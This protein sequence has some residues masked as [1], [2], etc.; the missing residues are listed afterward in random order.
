MISLNDNMSIE[1]R[2][3]FFRAYKDLVAMFG[4]ECVDAGLIQVP[5]RNLVELLEM[6]H[7]AD[8]YHSTPTRGGTPKPC[9]MK[10]S[11]YLGSEMRSVT[12]H[13]P[14]D[15]SFTK[16]DRRW[17]D[18]YLAPNRYQGLCHNQIITPCLLKRFPWLSEFRINVYEFRGGDATEEFYV[19]L[20]QR[21]EGHDSLYVPYTALIAGDADAIA[22]RMR[23]YLSW[24][25]KEKG[26]DIA[27]AVLNTDVAKR[28]LAHVR[29]E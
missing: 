18:V 25:N 15:S 17:C 12:V 20:G 23:T 22:A 13:H 8:K 24:Y 2:R 9:Y 14:F 11:L 7:P 6:P 21:I 10:P 26:A 4:Q 29:G 5:V 19:K 3:E 27:E 16:Y 28:F 1:Q